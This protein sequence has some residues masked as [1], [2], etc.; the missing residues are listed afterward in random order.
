MAIVNFAIPNTLDKRI[1]QVIKVASKAELFR[2]A[3]LYFMDIINKPQMNVHEEF[4][5]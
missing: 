1:N 5:Y 4:D 2:F 3:V